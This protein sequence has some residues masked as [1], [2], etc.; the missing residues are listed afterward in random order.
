M[1]LKV[2]ARRHKMLEKAPVVSENY[3]I[4]KNGYSTLGWRMLIFTSFLRS[5]FENFALKSF[6]FDAP[7]DIV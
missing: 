5:S 3:R 7:C 1:S 2:Y 6:I 4:S